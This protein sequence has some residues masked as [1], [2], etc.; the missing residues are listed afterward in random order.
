MEFT[1][2]ELNYLKELLEDKIAECKEDNSKAAMNDLE[3]F[4]SILNK[5]ESVK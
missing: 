4:E 5:L 1:L 3:V 2:N